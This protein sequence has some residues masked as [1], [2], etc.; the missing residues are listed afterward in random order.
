MS[1][2]S[3]VTGANG[4]LGN[5]LVRALL[6][7]GV[8]VRASVRKPENKIPFAGLDCELV[9]ADLLD[10]NSLEKALEGVDTLYQVAAVFKLWA[11]NVEQ[12]ILKP[13]VKGTRNVLEAAA[14]QKTRKI[15]YVSSV[16][17]L[18][19]RKSPIDET[20]WNPDKSNPYYHSKKRSEEIAWEIAK[21]HQLNM[22]SALPSV[23]VGPNCYRLTPSMSVLD[24][25]L[26][27][28]IFVD[29]N[30]H[31]NWVDV[32]D[33]AHGMILAAEK[34][35]NGERYCLTTESP[36]SLKRVTELAKQ[37][38]PKVRVPR[39]QPSKKTLLFT[40]AMMEKIARLTKTEPQMLRNQV[41]MYY[42]HKQIIDISKA[43][44]ELAYDPKPPEEAILK[45]LRYL[46]HERHAN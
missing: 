11:K 1:K 14:T 21:E 46:Y 25:A 34:G 37:V 18:D 43:K 20:T 42:G 4:H 6:D 9:Y 3:L 38:N 40:A 33:V 17:A 5:N 41:D 29:V 27:N 24:Q 8:K 15:V 32:R 30:F 35:K 39:I 44:N 7:K 26:R 13:N 12:E 2:L 36:V 19:Q 22:V 10:K 16:A 45:A 23:M 28:K 31:F